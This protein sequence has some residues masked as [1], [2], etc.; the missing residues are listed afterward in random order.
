[1]RVFI[2]ILLTAVSFDI[3]GQ[4]VSKRRIYVDSI[5][6]FSRLKDFD[7][8]L[9]YY[10]K[11][12]ALSPAWPSDILNKGVFL[13]KIKE[14]KAAIREFSRAMSTNQK[15]I[16]AL[17]GRG[18]AYLC[19]NKYDSSIIDFSLALGGYKYQDSIIYLY[20]SYAYD[21][22]GDQISAKR[23][24]D[25]ALTFHESVKKLHHSFGLVKYE[26]QDLE[27][28][29]KEY[30]KVVQMDDKFWPVIKDRAIANFDLQKS[31]E[32]FKDC[33][34]YLKNFPN[35]IELNYI[36]SVLFFDKKDYA[37]ALKHVRKC[38]LNGLETKEIYHLSGLT[39][40]NLVK[41]KEAIDD[42][43]IALTMNPTKQEGAVFYN[44][45]G[46]C[47][48]NIK[49]KSGCK[50]IL[51]AIKRGLLDAKPNYEYECK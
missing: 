8:C 51:E 14:Y 46:I 3:H 18:K 7:K 47:K 17:T 21:L 37:S 43:T 27:G 28:A 36:A 26:M 39:N 38:K 48:N 22:L 35:D 5:N 31:E 1:M 11:I 13:Y 49:P 19:L 45:I 4:T 10:D 42:L 50:E 23:D 9:V 34:S 33:V 25:S 29:I 40:Y 20:R 16:T 2:C 41:D 24:Y 32:S 12:I 15:I 44:I 6:Y 30:N